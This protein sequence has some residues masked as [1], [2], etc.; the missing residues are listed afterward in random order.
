VS[1]GLSSISL[2]F[3]WSDAQRLL[4]NSIT[5]ARNKAQSKDN[6]TPRYGGAVALEGNAEATFCGWVTPSGIHSFK[7]ATLTSGAFVSLKSRCTRWYDNLS[8]GG[9][10]L[11]AAN[12]ANVRFF[13]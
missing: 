9:G 7:T 2:H 11:Y 8:N 12:S 5:F 10:A 1:L 6:D 13:E 4:S 3:W